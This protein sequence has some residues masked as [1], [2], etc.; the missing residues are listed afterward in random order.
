[1]QLLVTC[2]TTGFFLQHCNEDFEGL[3]FEIFDKIPKKKQ[4]D[5]R[6]FL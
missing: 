2:P 3:T 1:M 4:K 5:F 6:N